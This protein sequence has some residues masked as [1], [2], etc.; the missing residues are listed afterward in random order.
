MS[1]RAVQRL[2]RVGCIIGTS[3]N[4]SGQ[5]VPPVCV[6][7]AG[8]SPTTHSHCGVGGGGVTAEFIFFTGNLVLLLQGVG[9][10]TWPWRHE[11][12]LGGFPFFIKNIISRNTKQD[13]I[14][15]VSSEFCLFRREQKICKIPFRIL[16]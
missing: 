11:E 5:I 14:T 13:E 7:I 1:T 2:K 10:T 9:S 6:P 16:S 8:T 15:V 3:A 4:I 12:P